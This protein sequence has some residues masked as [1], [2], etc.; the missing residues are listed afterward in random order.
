M[1][2][3]S[4]SNVFWSAVEANQLGIMDILLEN[5]IIQHSAIFETNKDTAVRHVLVTRAWETV[6]ALLRVRTLDPKTKYAIIGWVAVNAP[7]QLTDIVDQ[8]AENPPN[9][10]TMNRPY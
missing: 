1:A 8:V 10:P 6:K 4:L 7:E 3:P 2:D 5:G 9:Y